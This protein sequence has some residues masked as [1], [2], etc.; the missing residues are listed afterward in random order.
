MEEALVNLT[1]ANGAAES[2]A[3]N[4]E[5]YIPACGLVR[6]PEAWTAANVA[7]KMSP[8]LGG[9]YDWVR[10]TTGAL[11]KI[12]GVLTAEAGWYKLPTEVMGVRYMKL[13]SVNTGTG[14][15]ENQG[16]ARALQLFVKG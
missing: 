3:V 10:D 7:F 9:T 2:N 12:S 6:I 15:A 14:A 1:I 4:L 5:E 16:A 11:V 13:V 8:N